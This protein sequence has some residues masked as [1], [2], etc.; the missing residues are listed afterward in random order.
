MKKNSLN[1]CICVAIVLNIWSW[2]K[3][4]QG[5]QNKSYN[6]GSRAE[7][8]ENCQFENCDFEIFYRQFFQKVATHLHHHHI[9]KLCF[10]IFQ[11][12]QKFIASFDCKRNYQRDYFRESFRYH[13]FLFLSNKKQ[14][15]VQ[16]VPII[17]LIEN[18][19]IIE[20]FF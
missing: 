5:L 11:K 1:S 4:D 13:S 2:K 10:I 20:L 14:F 19:T 15:L 18:T 3:F 16:S 12:L 8:T 7:R 17:I 9:D 6:K